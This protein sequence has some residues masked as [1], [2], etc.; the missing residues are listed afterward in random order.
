MHGS[1]SRLFERNRLDI[2]LIVLINATIYVWNVSEG[3]ETEK[4]DQLM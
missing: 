3:A 4:L 2:S 1:T